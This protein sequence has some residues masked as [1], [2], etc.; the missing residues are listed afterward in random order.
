MLNVTGDLRADYVRA[1]WMML[2]QEA[3]EDYVV[4][5]GVAHSVKDLLEVAFA[6]VGL[7]YGDHVEIDP[8]FLR[9]AEVYHLLGD[10][11]KARKKLGWEPSVTFEELLA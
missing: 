1:M 6:K 3:P 2:Q 8:E 11:T 10:Y 7:D 5:T 9:P 4:A